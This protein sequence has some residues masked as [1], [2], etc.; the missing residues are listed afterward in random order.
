MAGFP[1][2]VRPVPAAGLE[3]AEID[4]ELVL[5]H[6]DR[7]TVVYCN[8]TASL[9]W[10]LCDGQRTVEEIVALLAEAWPEDAGRIRS[11]VVAT[12]EQLVQGGCLKLPVAP[13]GEGPGEG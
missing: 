3:L 4:G 1:L 2:D 12:L 5:L 13:A 8:P 11:D 10:R 7:E 6:A 9:V